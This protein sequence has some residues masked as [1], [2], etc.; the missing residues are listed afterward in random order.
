[1]SGQTPAVHC[2][3]QTTPQPPQL[4]GSVCVS[5]HWPPHE[6]VPASQLAIGTWATTSLMAS[7]ETT[8]FPPPPS[9][10][11]LSPPPSPINVV[12]APPHAT[13]TSPNNTPF[14][15]EKVRM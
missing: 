10:P 6:R 3:L 14:A 7:F 11:P 15:I 2:V 8:S 9:F 5:T 12:S 13:T 1:M 4:F